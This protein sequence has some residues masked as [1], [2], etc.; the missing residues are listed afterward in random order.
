MAD[1]CWKTA[2]GEWFYARTNPNWR[3]LWWWVGSKGAETGVVAQPS[4]S[5][6]CSERESFRSIQPYKKATAASGPL[7]LQ[8]TVPAPQGKF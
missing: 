8:R 6:G 2:P 4:H 7:A 3:T 1:K 5:S